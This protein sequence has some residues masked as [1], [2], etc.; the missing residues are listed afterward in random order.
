M[1]RSQFL[2]LGEMVG[3]ERELKRVESRKGRVRGGRAGVHFRILA[4]G[5]PH[6]EQVCFWMWKDRRPGWERKP[7]L[8]NL[9]A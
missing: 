8:I 9:L 4:E 7:R 3:G 1:A 6:D 2:L 5:Y